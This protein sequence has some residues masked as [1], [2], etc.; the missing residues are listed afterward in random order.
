MVLGEVNDKT[1]I[2]KGLKLM[3]KTNEKIEIECTR[4]FFVQVVVNLISTYI[5]F[6]YYIPES[7]RGEQKMET[8]HS[9]TPPS[10]FLKA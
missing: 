9:S 1:A 7:L 3:S 6:L 2:P 8:Q 5:H 10:Q 4:Y